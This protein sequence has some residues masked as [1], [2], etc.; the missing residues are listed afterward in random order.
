MKKKEKEFRLKGKKLYL[1]YTKLDKNIKFLKEEALNQLKLKIKGIKEYVI[2]QEGEHLHCFLELNIKVDIY[3]PNYLNLIFNGISYQ[4]NYQIGERKQALFEYIIK[5]KNILTNMN[6][7]QKDGRL[8]KPEEHLFY[9]CQDESFNKAE[10]LL[11]E[12]LLAAKKGSSSLNS[13]N[14]IKKNEIIDYERIFHINGFDKLTNENFDQIIDWLKNGINNG[15]P[16]TMVLYGPPG[17]GKTQLGRSIFHFMKI[18]YLEISKIQDFKKLDLTKHRGILVDDVDFEPLSRGIG[19]N[20][21]DSR[22]SKTIDVKYG[23]VTT[24]TVIPKIVTTNNENLVHGSLK[25]LERRSKVIFIPEFISSKFDLHINIQNIQNIQQ[26]YYFVHN[27]GLSKERVI[28]M[29]DEITKDFFILSIK[30]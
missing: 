29:E 6:L 14:L 3:D 2:F 25:E 28:Y 12:P 30:L 27:V 1:T 7:P 5:D 24:E 21:L 23:S 20:I 11:Y 4:G 15:F 26:N 19:L 9:I 8:L 22:A 17:T 16:V 18:P 13:F 10:E